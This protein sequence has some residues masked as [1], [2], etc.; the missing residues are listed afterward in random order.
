MNESADKLLLGW[1]NVIAPLDAVVT[2][3]RDNVIAVCLAARLSPRQRPGC[4]ASVLLIWLLHWRNFK[5]LFQ[6]PPLEFDLFQNQIRFLQSKQQKET[7]HSLD[8]ACTTFSLSPA[9]SRVFSVNYGRHWVQFFALFLFCYHPLSLVCFHTSVW[10]SLHSY[11]GR[12][13]FINARPP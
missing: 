13:V 5:L 8:Q 11:G 4:S 2:W 10:P 7:P 1:N 3:H 12:R 9:A 6:I